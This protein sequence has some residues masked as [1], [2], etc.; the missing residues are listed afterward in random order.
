MAEDKHPCSGGLTPACFA[1]YP[2]WAKL[3]FSYKLLH[4]LFPPS[5]TRRLPKGLFPGR[6]G[7]G[8]NLPPGWIP[9]PGVIVP[10]NYTVPPS[11]IPFTYF[12]LPEG[13]TW[14][15][16]FPEGWKAGD[17]LPDGVSINANV[18]DVAG[19]SAGDPMPSGPDVNTAAILP[20]G[21]SP[22]NP[23]P[24]WFAPGGAG[25]PIP[26]GGVLPPLYLP[27]GLQSPP[28]VPV[29]QAPSVTVTE[30]T[31]WAENGCRITNNQAAWADTRDGLTG[32]GIY[33]DFTVTTG[34]V[35]AWRGSSAHQIIRFFLSVDLTSIPSGATITAVI[36]QMTSYGTAFCGV[37][38]QEGTQE[39]EMTTADFDQLTGEYFAGVDWTLGENRLE[40][41]QLGIDFMNTKIG[42]AA[43]VCLR[44]YDHDYLNVQPEV[45]DLF[46][47]GSYGTR[48]DAGDDRPQ[49][50]ITYE[51]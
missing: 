21:W 40:F 34:I 4:T 7:P 30:T 39:D 35:Q 17:P 45:N 15:Q 9:P 19:W 12:I 31:I 43:K 24:A 13:L 23:P 41:N 38:V 33:C 49:F 16:V 3:A 1:A 8:A 28:H 32:T 46:Q 11:W 22:T 47:S 51:Q 6:I 37:S 48:E 36:L 27:P 10:P 2:D 18:I 42:A 20:A 14:E 50:I 44:E 5:I 26:P 29:S 25:L